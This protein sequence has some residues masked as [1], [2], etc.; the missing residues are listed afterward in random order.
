M[1]LHFPGFERDL[2]G[3]IKNKD[4]EK[5]LRCLTGSDSK[6]DTVTPVQ[7]ILVSLM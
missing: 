5:N 3:R 2:R 4:V 7:C 1:I 6:I